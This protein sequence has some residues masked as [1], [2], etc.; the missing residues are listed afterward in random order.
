MVQRRLLEGIVRFCSSVLAGC[1]KTQP[2]E[3]RLPAINRC[4]M[5]NCRHYEWFW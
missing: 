3:N 2:E 4:A 5:V 1:R